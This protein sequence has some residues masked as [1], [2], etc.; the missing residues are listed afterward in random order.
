MS[1]KLTV[2][3]SVEAAKRLCKKWADPAERQKMEA[4]FKDQGFT[5]EDIQLVDS[6]CEQL[7]VES[8]P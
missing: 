4:Y 5:V 2:E 6:V 1:K 3:M 8:P 7:A